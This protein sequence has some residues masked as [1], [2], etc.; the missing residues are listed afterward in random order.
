MAGLAI[1]VPVRPEKLDEWREFSLSLWEGSRSAEF[2]AFVK[3]SGLSRSRCWLQQGPEGPVAI[4]LYEGEKPAGFT[5]L[6]STS[7][8]PFAVWFRERIKD[9]HGMDLSQPPGP[10]PELLTDVRVD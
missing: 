7:P 4:V 2:A 1:A 9:L 5:E 6:M 8:E 10:P 3:K